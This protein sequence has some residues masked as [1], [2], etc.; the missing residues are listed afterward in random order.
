[1]DYQ[2]LLQK[3]ALYD[4]RKD[5]LPEATV[6]SYIQAFELEYT[7]HSTAIEGNTLSLL[8]T[9][10]LLEEGLSVGGKKLREIYEVVNA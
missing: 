1:M 8:E 2:I 7:H 9:K 6:K 3:K 5:T 10:V 4:Q